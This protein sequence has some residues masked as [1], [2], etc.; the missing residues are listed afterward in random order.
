MNL[1]DYN[2]SLL[3]ETAMIQAGLK[4]STEKSRAFDLPLCVFSAASI[5]LSLVIMG[6]LNG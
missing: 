5:V 4:T 6:L 2:F 3:V 1:E